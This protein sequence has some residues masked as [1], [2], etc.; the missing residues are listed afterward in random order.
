M[1]K[2]V[3]NKQGTSEDNNK[4]E[5]IRK[6]L[7]YMKTQLNSVTPQVEERLT[8]EMDLLYFDQIDTATNKL[9]PSEAIKKTV[10][11]FTPDLEK[12]HSNYLESRSQQGKYL[13]KSDLQKAYLD[14]NGLIDIDY[15]INEKLGD[16]ASRYQ[17]S[18]DTGI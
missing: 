7:N 16:Y 12:I 4:A 15:S 10:D 18:E 9:I 11:I 3:N 2:I 6:S 14:L 1:N 13:P 5:W 8:K 17:L